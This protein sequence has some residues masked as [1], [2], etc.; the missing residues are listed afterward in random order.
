MATV[1]Q[2]KL[3][4]AEE[5]MAADLGEGRFEL[6]RGEVIPIPPGSLLH[7]LHCANVCY[8]LESY[9]RKSGYGYGMIFGPVLT[10]RD[11]DTVRGA[12]FC[13]YSQERWPRSQVGCN[14]PPAV[15]N[16]VVEVYTPPMQ[17]G[18]VRRKVSEYLD[19]EVPLVMVLHSER[20]QVALYRPGEPIPVVL[21]SDDV[22]ENL[23]ELPGFR[24]AV[25]DFFV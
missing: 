2:P 18:E 23:P 8:A 22:I 24:C 21:A 11:P 7:G 20:R 16:A 3:L 6:V 25:A 17:P 13:F 9:G 14:L 15:A 12:D 19:A 1:A 4:T 5:F 10:G